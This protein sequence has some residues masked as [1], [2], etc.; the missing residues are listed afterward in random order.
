MTRPVTLLTAGIVTALVVAAALALSPPSRPSPGAALRTSPIAPAGP[1]AADVALLTDDGIRL[2][3]A[4]AFPEACQRF[5]DAVE[6]EPDSAALHGTVARC[7]GRWGWQALREGRPEEAMTLF[8]Q[9]LRQ[10]PGG[11]ELLTGLGVA[12]IHAG[13]TEVA[14]EALER[15][16]RAR[17]DPEVWVLLAKIYDQ[18]DQTP[19]ALT[20]LERLV[21]DGPLD[22]EVRRLLE[23]LQR[24]HAAETGLGRE[25]TAHFVLK[26]RDVGTRGIVAEVLEELYEDLAHRLGYR[27][28]DKLVVILYPEDRFQQVAATHDWVGGLFDGK[29]RL[30][31]RA[32]DSRTVSLERLLAHELT[33]AFVH[34]MARGRAPRWLQEGLAEHVEGVA[35]DALLRLPRG[36]S[37]AG[38]EALLTD[39][40]V[41]KAR[42]GYEA[43]LWLVRDLIERRGLAGVADLLERLGRGETVSDAVPRVYG[44]PLPELEFQWRRVLGG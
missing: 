1:V 11:G 12:A 6:R 41:A 3:A 35:D 10:T 23:K 24:E 43:A 27:P 9:G 42:T 22:N 5:T 36:V 21:A 37:L 15:A 39:G 30:I 8:R 20:Y 4:R 13:R 38:V 2:F 34:Q 31:D 14:L 33:H 18:R 17:P 32:L 29:I 28:R 40:D 25:E 26:Y 19:R 16:V 44:L 7:F